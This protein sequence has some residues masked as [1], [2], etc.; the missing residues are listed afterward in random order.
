MPAIKNKKSQK[1]FLAMTMMWIRSPHLVEL[2]SVIDT[3]LKEG[4]IKNQKYQI[5]EKIFPL[6][7]IVTV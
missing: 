7:L 1:E 5:V 3:V 2:D 6:V 4:G